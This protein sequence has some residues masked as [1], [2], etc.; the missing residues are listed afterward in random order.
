M[1]NV[2]L[3]DLQIITFSYWVAVPSCTRTWINYHLSARCRWQGRQQLSPHEWVCEDARTCRLV[4]Y[5]SMLTVTAH[6]P[7]LTHRRL[8]QARAA[9]SCRSPPGLSPPRLPEEEDAQQ[10]L[11]NVQ[12]SEFNNLCAH[13]YALIFTIK[14]T[15]WFIK[16]RNHRMHSHLR[17]RQPTCHSGVRKDFCKTT[18]VSL[19]LHLMMTS[20]GFAVT[21]SSSYLL[22]STYDLM[23]NGPA[24]T[25]DDS[26]A[27]PCCPVAP[28]L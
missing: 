17:I 26:P 16:L 20:D 18:T 3:E 6:R 5:A 12:C 19:S 10:R 9:A 25:W 27:G 21:C 24:W 4:I 15:G 8:C 11:K 23:M 2:G 14:W 22:G 7:A 28:P 1:S 13:I